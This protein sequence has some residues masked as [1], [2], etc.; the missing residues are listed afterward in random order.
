LNS[1]KI[2][3]EVGGVYLNFG[4]WAV[5]IAPA[6]LVLR[7]FGVVSKDLELQS[8]VDSGVDKPPEEVKEDVIFVQD[9]V[10]KE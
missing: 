9:P 5:S 10:A 7:H 1:T 3:S 2:F 4:L 8:A 6:W